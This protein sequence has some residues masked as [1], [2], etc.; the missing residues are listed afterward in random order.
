MVLNITQANYSTES[1]KARCKFDA[2]V[3]QNTPLSFHTRH[4]HWDGVTTLW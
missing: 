3:V 2:I 4:T 1:P